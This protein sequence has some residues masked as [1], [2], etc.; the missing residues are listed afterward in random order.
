M[1]T[2]KATNTHANKWSEADEKISEA[3]RQ[4]KRVPFFLEEIADDIDQA[5]DDVMADD[6]TEY[7]INKWKAMIGISVR[8]WSPHKVQAFHAMILEKALRFRY[9]NEFGKNLALVYEQASDVIKE[10]S[11]QE[12]N[13]TEA[14]KF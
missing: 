5:L 14:V 1:T 4:D 8:D 6:S 3:L 2:Y 10:M 12:K 11:T 9:K 13:H 7:L